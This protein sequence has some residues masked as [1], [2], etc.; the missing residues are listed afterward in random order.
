MEELSQAAVLLDEKEKAEGKK[1]AA[2]PFSQT[3]ASP[4]S[5][6]RPKRGGAGKRK[7]VV[8]E[9]PILKAP[10]EEKEEKKEEAEEG[11]DEAEGIHTMFCRE[12]LSY[13][14]FDR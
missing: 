7:K 2:V 10:S 14:R 6:S 9:S 11:D 13:V 4:P 12:L 8:E 3:E 1:E 5:S